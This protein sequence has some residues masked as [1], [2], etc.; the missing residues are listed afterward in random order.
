MLV[1]S[2]GER[3][4]IDAGFSCRELE[5]RLREVDV[6]PET[7][8][9]VVLTHEHQDHVRGAERFARRFEAAVYATSGTLS[10]PR[11]RRLRQRAGEITSGE[12]FG[13]PGFEIEPFSIEHDARE[14]VGFLV[15][16]STGVRLGLAADLGAVSKLV[17]WRLRDLDALLIETNHDLGML[18]SGPYPWHLKQRVASSRGH[19]S[20]W[21]A[22][23]ALSALVGDSLEHVVLY[24]LSETNN[25]PALALAAVEEVLSALGAT[26]DLTVTTQDQPGRWLELGVD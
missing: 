1:E 6:E 15:E 7:V 9:T 2:E 18:R 17:A 25:H 11:L 13:V 12:R 21:D 5:R 24:H 14:P 22:S 4:L 19:L 10:A 23:Q 3:L 8:S 16:S 20:N 26:P